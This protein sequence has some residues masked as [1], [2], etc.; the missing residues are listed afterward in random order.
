MLLLSQGKGCLQLSVAL[1]C[2]TL[3]T[4]VWERLRLRLLSAPT[5]ASSI[6]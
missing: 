1:R 6:T 3:Y 2:D 5:T 4:F